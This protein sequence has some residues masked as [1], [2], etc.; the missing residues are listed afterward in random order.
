MTPARNN[1]LLKALAAT[2]LSLFAVAL[3]VTATGCNSKTKPTPANFTQT[4]N[5]YFLEHSDCL[6]VD[7]KFPYATADPARTKQMNTLVKS[8]LLESSFEYAV[9]TT[10]YTP[11]TTG[12]RY[13]PRFCYGHRTITSI[14][15][16]TPPAKGPTGYP[17]TH[18]TFHYKMQDV[19][20]WAK[21]PDVMAAFPDMARKTSGDATD[22][23]TLAQTLSGWQVPD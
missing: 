6:L 17:E 22:K 4:L 15:S 19:P 18:V 10:R 7:V 1:S 14:D 3:L 20:V 8:L 16:F 23:A 21:S 2:T 9:H 5:A 11:T 12:A 13:A